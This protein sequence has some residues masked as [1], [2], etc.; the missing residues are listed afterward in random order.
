MEAQ[1]GG[2][3][4]FLPQG[5]FHH[6]WNLSALAALTNTTNAGLKQ[7]KCTSHSSGGCKS[8]IKVCPGLVSGE[9]GFSGLQMAVFQLCTQMVK[10]ALLSFPL[11]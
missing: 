4:P 5:Y 9:G 11:L 1:I 2:S 10:R 7:Q 8:K 6:S 3:G